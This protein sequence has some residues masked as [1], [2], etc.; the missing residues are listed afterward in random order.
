[1]QEKIALVTKGIKDNNM[2]QCKRIQRN[3]L[4]FRLVNNSKM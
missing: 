4:E 2:L 3:C 1:M